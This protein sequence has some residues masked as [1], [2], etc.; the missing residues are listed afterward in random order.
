[1]MNVIS[2]FDE[3]LFFG[4]SNSLFPSSSGNVSGSIDLSQVL[5]PNTNSN[6]N[7][8]VKMTVNSKSSPLKKNKRVFEAMSSDCSDCSECSF[9]SCDSAYS[10]AS[11]TSN[12]R[13]SSVLRQA[14]S[15]SHLV[16]AANGGLTFARLVRT[17]ESYAN[18]RGSGYVMEIEDFPTW[19]TQATEKKYKVGYNTLGN[20]HYYKVTMVVSFTQSDKALEMDCMYESGE[21][22]QF[23]TFIQQFAAL[24]TSEY[25]PSHQKITLSNLVDSEL[26]NLSLN[27]PKTETASKDNQ[28]E[29]FY[30][31]PE[32][33]PYLTA[34]VN[35]LSTSGA[36]ASEAMRELY[37]LSKAPNSLALMQV[38]VS[39]HDLTAALAG[40]FE[41]SMMVEESVRLEALS[42]LVTFKKD[43]AAFA[44]VLVDN[45]TVANFL[46]ALLQSSQHN[47]CGNVN[48]TSFLLIDYETRLC[49]EVQMVSGNC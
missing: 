35:Q 47:C 20:S 8:T 14:H 23:Y 21:K 17:F 2:H 24:V 38:L 44:A 26:C 15:F 40:L 48:K 28:V 11:N 31:L 22:S 3:D 4:N 32:H 18:A 36:T 41:S 43:I 30:T 9:S 16:P 25:H 7:N 12:K 6:I 27:T 45:K 34:L 29:S 1:M 39:N 46:N 42:V 13:R 33:S 10:V 5:V 37:H 19:S 49:R